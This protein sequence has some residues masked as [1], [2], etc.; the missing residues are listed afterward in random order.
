MKSTTLKVALAVI[1]TVG[2]IAV[3]ALTLL[4]S[5]DEKTEPTPAAPSIVLSPSINQSSVNSNTNTATNQSS[6]P[7]RAERPPVV[8]NYIIQPAEESPDEE[9]EEI[10]DDT[11]ATVEP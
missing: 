9:Y 4:G 3:A 5:E 1:T 6:K 11:E 7:E 2:S 10:V 8:N